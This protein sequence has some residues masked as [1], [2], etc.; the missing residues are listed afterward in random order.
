MLQRPQRQALSAENQ[1]ARC[2]SNVPVGRF[3]LSALWL[4]LLL[5]FLFS[6]D[7]ATCRHVEIERHAAEAA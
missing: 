6:D 5:V 1:H 3:D 2:R 4:G 7:A